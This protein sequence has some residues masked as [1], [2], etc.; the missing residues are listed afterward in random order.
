MEIFLSWSGVHSGE[1]ARALNNW[2][3]QVIQAVKLFYSPDDL[4]KG[5]WWRNRLD[6]ALAEM[7]FGIIC[8][9]PDNRDNKWIHYEAGALDKPEG[10]V[11][12]T[13]LHGL[14]PKEVLPPLD[15]FAPTVAEKDDVLRLLRSING[16]LGE[17]GGTPLPEKFLTNNFERLWPEL[18]RSLQAAEEVVDLVNSLSL[19]EKAEEFDKFL[20]LGMRRLHDPLTDE[21]L[22]ARLGNSRDIKVLKTWFPE[23]TDIENGLEEAI[24]QKA[25]VRLLLCK[26]GSVVLEKRSRGAHTNT[27]WGSYMVYHAVEKIYELVQATPGAD[28]QVA[29]YDAWP[30]CPVIWYG[31]EILMGFY[32]RG[33]SSP[34]WPWISVREGSRLAGILNDQFEELWGRSAKRLKSPDNVKHIETADEMKNWLKRNKR[35]DMPARQRRSAGKARSRRAAGDGG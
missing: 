32:F 15:K 9:T 28:V 34:A 12:W 21:N 20:A 29:I 7:R 31:G 10:G 8:L 5:A 3:P 35:F 22:Q 18:E 1:V 14:T 26:P 27:S 13:F 4:E 23:S 17:A 30:G 6:E 2:L 16:K 25:R 11:V 24:K 33:K 19:S